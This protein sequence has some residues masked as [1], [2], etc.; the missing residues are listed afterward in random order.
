MT[1][2]KTMYKASAEQ[3]KQI[4]LSL[5][6][7]GIWPDTQTCMKLILIESAVVVNTLILTQTCLLFSCSISDN[8]TF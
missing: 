2:L 3:L 1:V 7:P 8:T 6:S 5:T 4:S